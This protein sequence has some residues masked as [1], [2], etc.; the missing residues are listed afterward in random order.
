LIS[1]PAKTTIQHMNFIMP[2]LVPI[3]WALANYHYSHTLPIWYN[4]GSP[5]LEA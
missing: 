4:H 5:L 2:Q 3:N 1:S